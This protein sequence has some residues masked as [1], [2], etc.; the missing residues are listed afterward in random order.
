MTVKQDKQRGTWFFVV[1]LPP[2]AG[3]RQQLRRRGFK[4]KKAAEAAERV[5][6]AEVDAGRYVRPSAEPL[7]AFLDDTWLP[8]RAVD[9]RPSTVDGY[10]KA[11]RRIKPRLGDAKLSELDAAGLERFYGDLFANGGR[12]GAPLSAKTVA[13][14]AGVLAVALSDAV[15]W[16]LIPQNPASDA[17]LPRREHREMRA[18]T[19]A[20]A[21][22]F[23]QATAEE[24]MWPIWRLVI[25]T[26]LRR[27]ELCGLRWSDIDDD[28]GVL[29]VARNRVATGRDVIEGEPKTRAGVR[30][31]SLDANTRMALRRWGAQV[32]EE[33]LR[34]GEAYQD[35]GLVVADE[36]GVPP[37]PETLTRWWREAVKRAG[38]PAIRLHDARHTAATMMLRAGV[39]V[40]VVS[41]R[42]GHADV[43]VTMRVY[44]HVTEQDDQAAAD[45]VGRALGGEM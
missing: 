22:E 45:A 3:K 37:H 1:D 18:W 4:T 15:R 35:H 24:R 31:V 11:I 6:R 7:G 9:L 43:A 30:R 40:K 19:E 32:A 10:R 16:K 26:G 39:P 23:L 21:S 13:N 5:V 28:A 38:L 36:L 29:S 44:Q 12:D 41:Q 42:L 20:Q 33:R 14:T 17:R 25:A 8:A 27:G 34:A 2:S